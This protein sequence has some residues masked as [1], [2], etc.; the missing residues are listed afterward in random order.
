M[1]NKSTISVWH[2]AIFRH[3]QHRKADNKNVF[4]QDLSACVSLYY[5]ANAVDFHIRLNVFSLYP[6]VSRNSHIFML[7]LCP[8]SSKGCVPCCQE[9]RFIIFLA[10]VPLIFKYQVWGSKQPSIPGNY[11]VA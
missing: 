2:D 8:H 7:I 4:Y 11:H 5:A 9:G 3:T 6:F 10:V 1:Q